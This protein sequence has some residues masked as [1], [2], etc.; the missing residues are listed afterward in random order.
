[1]G[2]APPKNRPPICW[3]GKLGDG[4]AAWRGGPRDHA[5]EKSLKSDTEGG[6]DVPPFRNEEAVKT[7][8]VLSIYFY[9]KE[10]VGRNGI[11]ATSLEEGAKCGSSIEKAAQQGSAKED[12]VRAAS[13]IRPR[14][15][16]RGKNRGREG[17][18]GTKRD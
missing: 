8:N 2:K 18:R 14:K 15:V 12:R 7:G 5:P 1:L 11:R 13:G 6:E 16:A 9:G 10:V 4:T 3:G 17:K